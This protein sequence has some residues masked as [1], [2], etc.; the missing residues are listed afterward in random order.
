MLGE[1]K[2]VLCLSSIWK[3][4]CNAQAGN[5]LSTSWNQSGNQNN[6]KHTIS[7]G[8]LY[9]CS[10]IEYKEK[11]QHSSSKHSMPLKVFS[12]HESCSFPLSST[13]SC[14]MHYTSDPKCFS[15]HYYATLAHVLHMNSEGQVCCKKISA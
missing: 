14:Y 1:A 4:N 3:L 12:M 5:Q 7:I 8:S 2:Q 9:Y 10:F 11:N 13:N 15:I 6:S